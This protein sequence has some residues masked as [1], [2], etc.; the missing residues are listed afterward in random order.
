MRETIT[1]SPPP[2]RLRPLLLLLGSSSGDFIVTPEHSGLTQQQ[3]DF[4][5]IS[6]KPTGWADVSR[7]APETE[8]IS[9]RKTKRSAH[10]TERNTL[11]GLEAKYWASA[12]ASS[13]LSGE[14][15]ALAKS[16][17][18]AREEGREWWRVGRGRRGGVDRKR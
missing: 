12:A 3:I 13:S 1:S 10:H 18:E 11:R 5:F 8:L 16:R 9:H 4:L 14:E 15:F 7:E 6:E 17:R 2:K